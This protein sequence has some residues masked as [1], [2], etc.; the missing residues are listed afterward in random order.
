MTKK[1]ISQLRGLGIQELEEKISE[2]REKLAKER[3][4]KSSGTRPEKPATIGNLRKG[5][6]RSLTLIAEKK[7]KTTEARKLNG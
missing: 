3:S 5:I 1:T 7:K 2:L 4:I 6:A